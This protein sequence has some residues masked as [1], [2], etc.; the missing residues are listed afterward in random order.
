MKTGYFGAGLTA[1]GGTGTAFLIQPKSLLGT[2]WLTS[3]QGIGVVAFVITV[4]VMPRLGKKLLLN[5]L[6]LNSSPSIRL[7]LH[8][9]RWLQ[10]VS[11]LLLVNIFIAAFK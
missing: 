4:L 11:L 7:I 1:V 6:H 8:Y 5:P 9:R 2:Y 10:V 3:M